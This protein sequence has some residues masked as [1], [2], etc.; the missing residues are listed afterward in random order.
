MIEVLRAEIAAGRI[1]R[2]T[3]VVQLSPRIVLY[4][5]NLL[6]SVYT[7]INAD[8]YLAPDHVFDRSIAGSR[9]RPMAEVHDRLAQRPPY[10]AIHQAPVEL[11][12]DA[13][14]GYVEL[15]N[16][17]GVRLLRNDASRRAASAEASR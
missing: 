14:Q 17:D 6:F 13:L 11:A 1:T 12:P 3:H 4:K 16:R 9:L 7:G 2:D 8:T 10:V 15:F 5:D